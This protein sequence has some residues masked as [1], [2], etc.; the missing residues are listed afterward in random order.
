MNA[1]APISHNPATA[2]P[3]KPTCSMGGLWHRRERPQWVE[4]GHRATPSGITHEK[5][6]AE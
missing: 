3:T 2:L 5:L 4:S 6:S 1:A